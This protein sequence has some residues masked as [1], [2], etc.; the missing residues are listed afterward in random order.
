M[1]SKMEKRQLMVFAMAAYVL[2]YLLGILM[3]YGYTKQISLTAFPSAQMMYPAMGVM[4][5]FLLTRGTDREMPKAFY[6]CYIGVTVVLV[7]LTVGSVLVPEAVIE[8]PGGQMPACLLILQYVQVLGSLVC[9]VCLIAAGKKRREAYGLRWKKGK[10]SVLCILLFLVLYFLRVGIAYGAGGQLSLFAEIMANPQ[11]W[12][13]VAMLPLQFLLAYIAFFG[14][15]YGWRYYLQPLLQRKFGL[16]RGVLLLGVLWG[17]WHLP[18][19]IFFYVTPDKGLIMTV[20]QIITCVGLGI[21]FG[22]AYMKTENIWVPVIMHFLNNNLVLVISGEF[23]ADVME[24]QSVA[25]SD[26]PLALLLNGVLFGVFILAKV[27]REKKE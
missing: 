1:D 2:P 8:M 5:A 24:N 15:E 13:I 26:I 21:F 11:T 23:S 3:W 17:L 19:D 14:E 6:R 20:S 22:Y 12:I 25:W 10:T 7:V 4:L 16:R 27:Y 18:L 9:L